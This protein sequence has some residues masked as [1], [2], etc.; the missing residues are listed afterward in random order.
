VKRGPVI[1][2][3]CLGLGLVAAPAVFQM[4]TRAPEG[5]I[6]INEF[7]P[8]M[9]QVKIDQFQ[10][11]MAEIDAAVTEID[12]A[13]EPEVRRELDLDEGGFD[14]AFP[15]TTSLQ[16][17]WDGVY[18]D[19]NDDMLANIEDN[20]DN[21]AAVDALPPFAMFPW[22]FVV[23]GLLTA[24]VAT[25]VL[26]SGRRGNGAGRRLVVLAV[27]GVGILAAPAIF[28]MFTRAP[29]GGAMINDFEPLMPR[30][31]VQTI[32]GYFL[33]IGGGEGEMRNAVLPE[34]G[35]QDFP[36]VEAFNEDWPLINSEMAPMIGA[37][38]DNVENYAAVKALPPFALFPWFFV[39]PGLAILVLA[40]VARRPPAAIA[41][42]D[43]P[44]STNKETPR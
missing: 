19:M 21:F 26:I 31:R 6:M 14:E 39:I 10:G 43:D 8:Y 17:G 4:F 11:Y 23:P 16:D 28:Q 2:I 44:S 22:F 3:L 20:L 18:A 40:L 41:A 34:A 30:E 27:L 7:R 15:L 25:S 13:V 12:S 38:S 32:Q 35:A 9:T 37:M 33:V 1:A 36:A 29:D 24:G 5:G 42:P